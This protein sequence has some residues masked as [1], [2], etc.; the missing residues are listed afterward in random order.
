MN[1]SKVFSADPYKASQ[2][3]IPRTIDTLALQAHQQVF[4]KS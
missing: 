4:S 2:G 1:L 3:L